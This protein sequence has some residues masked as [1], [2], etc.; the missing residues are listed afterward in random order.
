V[1]F[2]KWCEI[3]SKYK[4]YSDLKKRVIN[5]AIKELE[6]K[7]DLIISWEEKKK[8]RKIV[9]FDFMFEEN[10]QLKLF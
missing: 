3:E 4:V 7:A 8:G 9:G 10:R 2:R 6:D 1:D 5:P